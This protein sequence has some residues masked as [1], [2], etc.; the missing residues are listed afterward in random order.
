MTRV[1]RNF[2]IG[3][4]GAALGAAA[5][6]ALWAQATPPVYVVIDISEMIDADAF[7]KAAASAPAPASGYLVRTQKA[8]QLDGGAAPARFVMIAFDSE[9]KAKEWFNSPA[10]AAVNAV[11]SKATKS[12]AFLVEGMPK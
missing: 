5:V 10:I 7:G 11:R 2:S 6:T 9:A 12:R 1:V 4:L 3:L 8:A